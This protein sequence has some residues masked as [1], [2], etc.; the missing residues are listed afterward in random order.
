MQCLCLFHVFYSSFMSLLVSYYWVLF[1][2]AT[3][4][5]FLSDEF[6]LNECKTLKIKQNED[7]VT[8]DEIDKAVKLR[9]KH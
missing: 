8:D 2:Q 3:E 6:S 7:S 9:K 4:S 5:K 1:A